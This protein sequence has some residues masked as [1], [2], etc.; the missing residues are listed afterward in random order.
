MLKLR[1][2]ISLL[3]IILSVY[4]TVVFAQASTPGIDKTKL[5][6]G[7]V[8][9]NYDPQK[10][11]T[12]KVIISK[13]DVKYTYNLKSNNSFPLQFGD[14][15]YTISILE[16]VEGNKYKLVKKEDVI[17]E[18]TNK[19]EVFLQS[20]QMIHWH[21]DMAP[22]KKARELTKNAQNDKDKV[23][24]I[25]NYIINNISYDNNKTNNIS[26]EYIP[27]I[28]ETLKVSKG[29]CYDYSALFAAMLR[30]VDVPTKLIMGRKND[31]D[32]YHAWNQVYL[33]DTNEWITIDT[34][35]DAAK[36]TKSPNLM[37]KN[38]KEY[39]IEKQY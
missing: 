27:S 6:A 21:N 33:K 30:S 4:S 25:Y 38:E 12:T 23:T 7:L 20:I 5:D 13:G 35:Y 32:T 10:Q 2:V 8:S 1:K 24:A 14:G 19:N 16:N 26:T 31:I 34:T 28:E 3:V 39:S 22:I 9:I 18:S 11:V 15:E 29:I 17:L 36:K 37:I